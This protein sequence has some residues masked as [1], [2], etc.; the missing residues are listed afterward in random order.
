MLFPD[1]RLTSYKG[2]SKGG[3]DIVSSVL[4]FKLSV[5]AELVELDRNKIWKI[6]LSYRFLS[7]KRAF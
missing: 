3:M 5:S 7:P 1:I 2:D 4:F 6:K